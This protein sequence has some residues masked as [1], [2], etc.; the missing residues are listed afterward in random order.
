MPHGT[1]LRAW[2]RTGALDPASIVRL[3][4]LSEAWHEETSN[5]LVPLLQGHLRRRAPRFVESDP[6]LKEYAAVVILNS[7]VR[8]PPLLDGIVA[9][10][11]A[12]S[13][14]PREAFRKGLHPMLDGSLWWWEGKR[15]G[16]DR[17][18][19]EGGMVR[20]LAVCTVLLLSLLFSHTCETDASKSATDVRAWA[21]YALYHFVGMASDV[22][23]GM[24]QISE[25]LLNQLEQGL[26][27]E[28]REDNGRMKERVRWLLRRVRRKL[29]VRSNATFL[30][31]DILQ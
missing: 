4:T 25:T 20:G 15:Q 27:T 11:H 26:Q 21:T 24:P 31:G 3:M 1:L 8:V 22:V 29:L 23:A 6:V 30:N 9:M 17:A 28:W 18:G 14:V 5:A 7:Y 10:E 2:S 13:R 19:E 16:D 12:R